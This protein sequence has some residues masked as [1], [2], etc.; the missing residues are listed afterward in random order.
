MKKKEASIIIFARYPVEGKVKTRL[1]KT[2][3]N[4]FAAYLYKRLAKQVIGS[5]RQVKN[6][7]AYVFY[8]EK[9]ENRLIKKWLGKKYFYAHQEG[10]DLGERMKNAFR[11]VFSH[12]AEKVIIV[13]TDI[14]D[15]SKKIVQAAISGLDETDLVIGPSDDGGY[16]LLGMKKYYPGLFENIKYSTHTVFSETI[17]AAENLHLSCSKLDVL[18][19]F[20]TEADIIRWIESDSESKIKNEVE[21]IYK[22]IKGCT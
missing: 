2:L 19:D 20:D 9:S 4:R 12:G 13:G 16:Y 10:N 15:I 11:K 14:P 18:H 3:G 17:V 21:S 8:S 1:A 22:E 7:Y 5:I 6:I